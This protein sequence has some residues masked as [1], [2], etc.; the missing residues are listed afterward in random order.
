MTTFTFPASIKDSDYYAGGIRLWRRWNKR[1][2]SIHTGAQ[3]K[4]S[5]ISL[6]A[7]GSRAAGRTF[8]NLNPADTRDVV[9]IFQ[10]SDREDVN[11]AI[12]AAS[13]DKKWRLVPAPR[14][15]AMLYKAAEILISAKKSTR[16]R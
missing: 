5:R 9:G 15:A 3:P 10:K 1:H 2:P 12:D 6:A 13:G 16:N 11:M 8:E 14:R 4:H 7:N